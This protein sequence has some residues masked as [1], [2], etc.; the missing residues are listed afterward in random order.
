MKKLFGIAILTTAALILTSAEASAW[1]F[2]LH[3]CKCCKSLCCTQYNAFSPFC[4][5]GMPMNGGGYGPMYGGPASAWNFTGDGGCM[6]QLPAGDAMAGSANVYSPG[7]PPMAGMP[8]Y[9]GPPPTP[10][11]GAPGQPWNGWSPNMTNPNGLPSYYPPG[12]GGYP[13]GNGVGR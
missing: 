5:D 3:S 11:A 4:C 2:P 1:W 6:G 10:G 13:S 12:V 9:N 7:A 8:I